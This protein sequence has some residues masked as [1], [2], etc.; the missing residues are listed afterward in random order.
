MP[1]DTLR[2]DKNLNGKKFYLLPI[3]KTIRLETQFKADGVLIFQSAGLNMDSCVSPNT[4]GVW[5]NILD[6]SN[7]S[8][9]HMSI[10]WGQGT[11]AFNHLRASNNQWGWEQ[12]VP[13]EGLFKEPNPTIVIYDHGDRY[14]VMVDYHTVAYFEKRIKKDGVAVVYNKDPDQVSPFS[15]TL[16]MT[17]YTSFADVI[18]RVK[19]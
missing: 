13:L 17:A 4:E 7:N 18:T 5:I 6:A 2:P 3:H 10:R 12:R 14:Q 11:I 1:T 16:A 8:I 15:N 9:L 19:S